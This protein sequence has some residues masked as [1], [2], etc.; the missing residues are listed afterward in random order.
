MTTR[1]KDVDLKLQHLKNLL[2]KAACPMMY[3]MD[4]FL[5]KSS[6]QQPITIQEVQS[7]T[8]TCKGYLQMLQASFSEITFRR[9][10][11]IKGDIQPQYKALCDDTTPVTDMLFGDDIK[12][13]IKEMDAE[14]SVFKK[15]G[16][17][18][19]LDFIN[20]PEGEVGRLTNL[21]RK[22]AKLMVASPRHMYRTKNQNTMMVVF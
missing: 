12:E 1:N 21:E 2:S 14:N 15:V 19:Q 13:K 4:M 3:M 10:S 22:S 6:N 17:E 18:N 7:Y 16:H 9:R 5:Q 8:V 20:P 11:F